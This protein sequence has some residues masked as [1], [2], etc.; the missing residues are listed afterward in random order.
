MK[1]P[2]KL[3]RALTIAAVLL[4]AMVTV[5]PTY[6]EVGGGG[7]DGGGGGGDNGRGDFYAWV[8]S[9][10]HVSGSGYN[11]GGSPNVQVDY[12][13]PHCW[14]QP[15]YTY[16]E[17]RDWAERIHFVWHHQ[18]PEDQRDASQWY[19]GTLDQIRPYENEPGKI[20]WFLTDDG[21][22][23]GWDCYINT[24]PFWIHVGAQPPADPG[25]KLIDPVDLALI[26]QANLSLPKPGFSLN[27]PAG[28]GGYRSYVGL[29][30]MVSVPPVG[31]LEVTAQVEGAPYLTATITAAPTGVTITTDGAVD[32]IRTQET[33]RNYTAGMK[34]DD[35][36]YIRFARA[37]TGGP[38][39]ITVTQHWRV[40]SNVPAAGIND[41]VGMDSQATIVVDEIQSVANG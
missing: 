4:A 15:E 32:T 31:P 27:P 3:R 36:C 35:G 21:T 16:D 10:V 14:Y 30:T 23:A 25:D 9:R 1:A 34:P 8:K 22:D 41:E 6:A 13:P 28:P 7:G 24:D 26:A 12:D 19:Q 40:T 2:R 18:G 11:G 33:C 38:Y 37:S 20:F 39:T 5:V 17:M 29:E